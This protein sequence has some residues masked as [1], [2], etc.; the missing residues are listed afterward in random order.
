MNN[1]EKIEAIIRY[2]HQIQQNPDVNL[3]TADPFFTSLCIS[4]VNRAAD[5]LISGAEQEDHHEIREAI[6]VNRG[7]DVCPVIWTPMLESGLSEKA[8]VQELLTIE[9]EAWYQLI[10]LHGSDSELL[11]YAECIDHIV[12]LL[13]QAKKRPTLFIG[14]ATPENAQFFLKTFAAI[15]I[16]TGLVPTHQNSYEVVARESFGIIVDEENDALGTLRARGLPDERII[17]QLFALELATWKHHQ[18]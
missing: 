2:L 8:V 3:P 1:A 15:C 7:W 10:E 11:T 13:E 6:I 4:T 16:V 9:I 14:R 17:D 18:V 12:T 5:L